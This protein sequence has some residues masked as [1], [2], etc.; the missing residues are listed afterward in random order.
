MCGCIDYE[1]EL[2]VYKSKNSLRKFRDRCRYQRNDQKKETEVL[3]ESYVRDKLHTDRLTAEGKAYIQK[4]YP[5]TFKAYTINDAVSPQGYHKDTK[6]R[7]RMSY[8]AKTMVNMYLSQIP[9]MVEEKLSIAVYEENRSAFVLNSKIAMQENYTAFYGMKECKQILR[10]EVR[11]SRATGILLTS[12]KEE[13]KIRKENYVVYNM[14]RTN[15]KINKKVEQKINSQIYGLM[16]GENSNGGGMAGEIIYGD[17]YDMVLVLLNNTNKRTEEEE[18]IRKR[19]LE[20][21]KKKWI[22]EHPEEKYVEEFCSSIFSIHAR[23]FFVLNG[24][25]GNLETKLLSYPRVKNELYRN[26]LDACSYEKA[27][28]SSLE[29]GYLM[30]RDGF[31]E[32]VRNVYVMFPLNLAKLNVIIKKNKRSDV[33]ILRSQEQVIR[34][35]FYIEETGNNEK[36]HIRLLVYEDQQIEEFIEEILQ[37]KNEQNEISVVGLMGT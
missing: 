25:S 33:I 37:I 30:S 29:D 24:I 34:S 21:T 14:G 6:R 15:I 19:I 12:W 18:E 17:N 23:T 10:L 4:K 13:Q 36:N 3:I 27:A 11:G 20:K 35:A 7:Q 1:S 31:G 16:L 5:N 28:I 8:V 22:K 9:F 32:I 26:I 2:L